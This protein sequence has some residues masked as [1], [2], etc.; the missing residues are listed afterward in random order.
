MATLKIYDGA[1]EFR[2]EIAGRF[3]PNAVEDVDR[4]WQKALAENLQ[5]KITIDISRL[6][7]YDS[8]GCLLLRKMHQHGTT[9]AAATPRS[10]IFLQEI[11]APTR[12]GPALIRQA[13]DPKQ[14]SDKSSG[15]NAFA[16]GE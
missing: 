12:R 5:R 2:I 6:S 16:A 11:T 10:L 7:G 13:T 3:T 9:I 15:M 1:D 14:R 8:S 4:I